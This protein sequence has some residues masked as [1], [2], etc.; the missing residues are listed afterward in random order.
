M[1]EGKTHKGSTHRAKKQGKQIALSSRSRESL[2]GSQHAHNFDLLNA[3]TTHTHTHTHIHTHIHTNTHT[4]KHKHTQND[5]R[6]AFDV[7]VQIILTEIYGCVV[8][9]AKIN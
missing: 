1:Y 8:R 6:D 5:T 4:H 2:Q 9:I 3:H 7:L